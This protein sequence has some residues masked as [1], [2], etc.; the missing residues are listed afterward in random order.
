MKQKKPAKEWAAT[1]QPLQE[2]R[3]NQRAGEASPK[4]DGEN[5]QQQAMRGAGEAGGGRG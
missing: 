4:H 1:M 2:E 3:D 5:E